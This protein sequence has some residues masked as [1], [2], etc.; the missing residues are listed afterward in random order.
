MAPVYSED[1]AATA[2]AAGGV[3]GAIGLDK[4]NA[5]LA[6][7]E[8]IA[9]E[10]DDLEEDEMEPADPNDWLSTM[11]EVRY[12]TFVW[13]GVVRR[14]VAWRGVAWRGVV[15]CGVV[16]YGAPAGVVRLTSRVDTG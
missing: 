10:E 13:A 1:G 11:G 5:M 7:V 3:G 9:A 4:L 6:D 14:G 2:N 15:W 8:E 12:V 16:W